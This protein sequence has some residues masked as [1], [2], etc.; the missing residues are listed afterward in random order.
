MRALVRVV[1]VD[2]PPSLSGWAADGV[3]RVEANLERIVRLAAAHHAAVWVVLY[4][5]PQSLYVDARWRDRLLLRFPRWFHE[6]EAVVGAQPGNGGLAWRQPLLAWG[7]DR[8][9][10]TLD[11]WP[12]FLAQP[13][14]PLL[15]RAGDVHWSAAGCDLVAHRLAAELAGR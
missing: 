5:D 6:R 1:W 8:K 12:L 14:W 10:P 13:D 2:H 3:R 15:F 7:R 4:P 11:L 9:V